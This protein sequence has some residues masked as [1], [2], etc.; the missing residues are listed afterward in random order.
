MKTLKECLMIVLFSCVC[1]FLFN[2]LSPGGIALVGQ[3]DMSKGVITAVT[4][5]NP[6]EHDLEI[7]DISIVKN[8]YDSG[9]TLFVDARDEKAYA[10]GHIKGAVSLPIGLYEENLEHFVMKYPP[11]TP[12]ITYCAGRTCQ[13]SHEL[14]QILLQF[15]YENVHVFI[16]GFPEWEK[17]GFPVE[18]GVE[19]GV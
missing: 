6:V 9:G 4:K 17:K 12:I 2:A 5:D 7:G 3:W 19:K 18:T 1:A 16:D 15:E 11:S 10:E 13:D 14:A 8:I